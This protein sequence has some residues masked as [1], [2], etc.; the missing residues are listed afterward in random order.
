MSQV[1]T[2][3]NN[4]SKSKRYTW[5]AIILIAVMFVGFLATAY[6]LVN[7]MIGAI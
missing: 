2:S 5:G 4:L 1:D 6:F 3:K 7:E